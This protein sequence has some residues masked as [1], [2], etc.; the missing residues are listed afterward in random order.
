MALREDGPPAPG[1]DDLADYLRWHGI[2]AK[3]STFD[4][5]ATSAGRTVLTE[6]GAENADLLVMGAYT[7]DRV[8]RLIFGGVTREVLTHGTIPV[9]MLD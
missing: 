2:E 1:A 9:L 7:R 4:G 5:H 8:N 6:A 3:T